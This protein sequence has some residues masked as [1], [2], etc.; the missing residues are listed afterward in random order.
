MKQSEVAKP[1]KEK[2][3]DRGSTRRKTG[4]D[5]SGEKRHLVIGNVADRRFQKI[6]IFAVTVGA[7]DKQPIRTE[8]NRKA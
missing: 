5:K 3:K 7:E 2:G 4:H 1:K 6:S 8:R